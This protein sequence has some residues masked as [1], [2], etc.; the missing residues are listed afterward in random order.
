MEF[1][2]IDNENLSLKITKNMPDMNIDDLLDYTKLVIPQI[3][4]YFT[5]ENKEKLKKYCNDEIITKVLEDKFT[6]RIS[7]DI[8]NIRVG[9]ATIKD[10]NEKKDIPYI[11][12]YTS[13][14]F[15]DD[16]SNNE[17]NLDGYDKYWNDNWTITFEKNTESQIINKCPN[18]G[19][20]MDFNN[21]K[22]MFTCEYC[23]NSVYYSKIDWKIVDISVNEINYNNN[24]HNHQTI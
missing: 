24:I 13:V 2:N 6:Y 8:D 1:N 4:H 17:Y 5:Y 11:K 18:C 7:K 22:H 15:F 12:V 10:Y 16:I 23:R 14:F 3:H 20:F 9:F 21:S 19:A